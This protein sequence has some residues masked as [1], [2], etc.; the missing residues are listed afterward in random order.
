MAGGQRA[1]FDLQAFLAA[2]TIPPDQ[3]AVLDSSQGL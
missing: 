3:E 1:G 2:A